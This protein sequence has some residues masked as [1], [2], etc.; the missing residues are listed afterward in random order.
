MA[1]KVEDDAVVREDFQFARGKQHAEEPIV[2][3]VAGVRGMALAAEAGD[4][5]GAC[6][7]A[8]PMNRRSQMRMTGAVEG[9]EACG[10]MLYYV[11]N[12]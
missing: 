5:C 3:L 2:V 12:A 7:T 4:A 11:G 6:Y 8:V 9:C 1:V 10:V